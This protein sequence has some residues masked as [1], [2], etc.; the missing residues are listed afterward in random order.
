MTA[1]KR[2][3]QGKAEGN[4]PVCTERGLPSVGRLGMPLDRSG[5]KPIYVYFALLHLLSVAPTPDEETVKHFIFNMFG[6][7]QE[8]Y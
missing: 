2:T 3:T 8:S 7:A 6:I 4:H 5:A 1:A